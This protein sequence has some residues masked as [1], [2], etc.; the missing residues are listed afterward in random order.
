VYRGVRESQW[1][2]E[3]LTSTQENRDGSDAILERPTDGPPAVLAISM[4]KVK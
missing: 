1:G 4:N 2:F 3:H